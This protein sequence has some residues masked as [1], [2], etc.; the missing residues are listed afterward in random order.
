MSKY[1][2]LARP[3]A[4]VGVAALALAA[5][6]GG[7]SGGSSSA[8]PSGASGYNAAMTSIV[9]VSSV[10][11]GTLKIGS[12][13][14]C[15][16]WDPARTYYANCWDMQRLFTRT[17]MGYVSKPG[18]AGTAVAPDL[19]SGPPTISSDV[20]TWTYHLQTG[21]K[22]DDGTPL[23]TADIKYGIERVF[24]TD[25]INGGPSSYY[26]TLLDNEK[27]PYAGPYKDKTG[28][29]MVDGAPSITT[30]D[31]TTITFHLTSP[32]SDFNYIM[33]LPAASPVP[34]AKDTG[35]NYTKHPS[36][37][38]PF[39]IDTYDVGKS[40]SFKRNPNWSQATDKIRTPH[41][42]AVTVQIIT[43]PDA[44]DQALKSGQIDVEQD[45]TGVQSTFQAEILS[46][47]NLKKYADKAGSGF[48]R[49][50]VIPPSVVPNVHCRRAIAYALNKAD[51]LLA[52][53]GSY[54]GAIANTM[55]L[56]SLPGYDPN[57]N[58]YPTGADNTGDVT[59]AKA[60]LAL[61]G[62]PNGFSINEAYV[63]KGKAAKVFAATQQALARVGITVVSAP[64]DNASYY[65]TW[66]GSPS[67]IVNH[68]LGLLQ[69][70]WGPDFPT[71]YGFFSSI[72]GPPIL[73][74]GNTNYA[75]LN[76]PVIN[77]LLTQSLTATDAQKPAIFK[78]LDAQVM[79]LAVM[80]P[81][82]YDYALDYRA[83]RLTNVYLQA[84]VGYIYDFVN[85]GV[86]DGK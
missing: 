62:Q 79:S 10:N 9:N 59:K 75:S 51:L 73:P 32:Y 80:I 57:A 83:P 35:A 1:R 66:I 53:G 76:D 68:K 69:A 78:Q 70:G 42:N 44:E 74:S 54:G 21:L 2:R 47:P 40:I 6:G 85:L 64:G 27:T 63:N 14:D 71:G 56:P 17:L 41:V 24:A 67:N 46:D 39:M 26:L 43:D 33:A 7:S 84:G 30:P 25:V 72:V 3:A 55:E 20:R 52:R 38:G 50:L 58:A 48:T 60:E 5:C 8:S 28:Q 4:V 49:Y 34:Q 77:G 13:S 37:T 45:G 22:W 65:S 15:D 36:A 31:A 18:T 23:T 81:Y 16:S 19:A 86:S 11:G 61:C 12:N 82:V 29:P